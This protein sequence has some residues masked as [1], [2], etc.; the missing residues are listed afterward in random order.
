MKPYY[1]A[2]PIALLM[3]GCFDS[4]SSSDTA[5]NT[6]NVSEP[7]DT[8]GP[9]PDTSEPPL[10]NSETAPVVIPTEVS[11]LYYGAF[12]DSSSELFV[13]SDGRTALSQILNNDANFYGTSHIDDAVLVFTGDV[14][15]VWST[16]DITGLMNID[17]SLTGTYSWSLYRIEYS[18]TLNYVKDTRFDNLTT[19]LN[20]FAGR[21]STT[22]GQ[23]VEI[24]NTGVISEYFDAERGCTETGLFELI[25][26]ARNEFSVTL[27]S[28]DCSDPALNN[29]YQGI[30]YFAYD[31]SETEQIKFTAFAD[32]PWSYHDEHSARIE[33]FSRVD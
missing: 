16:S 8:S 12:N 18:G 7:A 22:T 10:D 23:T 4:N 29:S 3:T 15:G 17:G 26:P 28:F 13:A 33:T 5:D 11:G 19:S 32:L 1:L 2:L 9:T 14:H 21:W 24:S 20:K 6:D 25:D 27:N 31:F 30:G